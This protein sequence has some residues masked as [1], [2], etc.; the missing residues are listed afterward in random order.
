MQYS[1]GYAKDLVGI[2]S[3]PSGSAGVV[4]CCESHEMLGLKGTGVSTAETEV[5][6]SLLAGNGEIMVSCCNKIG[7]NVVSLEAG[8]RITFTIA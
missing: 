4:G 5:K 8:R 3:P 7:I 2:S 6:G 1:G